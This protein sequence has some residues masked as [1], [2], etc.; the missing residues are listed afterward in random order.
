MKTY[1]PLKLI[2]K[3]SDAIPSCWDEIDDIRQS[4]GIDLPAWDPACYIPI[5]GAIAVTSR[6]IDTKDLTIDMTIGAAEIAA[7]APWRRY[8]EA[9]KFTPEMETMLFD[10]AEDLVIPVE[11]I[12]SMPFPCIYIEFSTQEFGQDFHGC[13]V[14]L[15]HDQKNGRKELRLLWLT[16]DGETFSTPVHLLPGGTIKDGIEA[17][18]AEFIKQARKYN[19]MFDARDNQKLEDKSIEITAKL[20]QLLLY[21]CSQNADIEENPFQKTVT[22]KPSSPEFI[23]DKFREIR[24]WDVGVRI[25]NAIRR[26][27]Q[28]EEPRQRSEESHTPGTPKRPHARCGHWH[29]FWSGKR[30]SQERKLVLHWVSPTFIHV[31]GESPVVIRKIKGGS[32]P[33]S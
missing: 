4:Q 1:P 25:A 31:D 12:R 18:D 17:M 16:Q 28:T 30:N 11:V 29:H 13:F 33:C 24:K 5:A 27:S 23:K 15:E 19:L 6:G 26:S 32:K 8:K 21:I 7:L 3:W 22:K 20:M 2:E 10:Q 14:H 9:Y